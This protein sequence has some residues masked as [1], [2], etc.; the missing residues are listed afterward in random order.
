L[1]FGRSDGN[2]SAKSDRIFSRGTFTSALQ[3]IKFI[4]NATKSVTKIGVTGGIAAGK[5]SL[6]QLWRA[7]GVTV[8]DT[9]VLAREA[10]AKDTETWRRV[11]DE[12]GREILQP[13]GEIDRARLGEIVFSDAEKRA[14]LNALVHPDVL[15]RSQRALRECAQRGEPCAAVCVPLLFEVNLQDNFDVIVAVGCTA[16]TQIERLSAS[17]LSRAHA[18]ARLRAQ[19]PVQQKLDAADF[20]V[21][22]NGSRELLARQ[23]EIL[24]VKI[25][26]RN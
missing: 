9:D 11:V 1:T 14:R 12:F 18:E 20:V 8:I 17:G 19:W 16:R 5:S 24:W 23:A 2:V 26:S 6:L 15:Q 13:N 7:R 4:P 22:N 3:S 21:W 10:L 25:C